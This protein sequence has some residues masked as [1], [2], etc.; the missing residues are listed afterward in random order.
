MIGKQANLPWNEKNGD[1][2]DYAM[3]A[4]SAAEAA[5]IATNK[6]RV[7]SG[8]LGYGGPVPVSHTVLLYDPNGQFEKTTNSV[9]G[10]AQFYDIHQ[11]KLTGTAHQLSQKFE[12]FEQYTAG[13]VLWAIPD[14]YIY[15]VISAGHVKLSI[16]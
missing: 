2:E 7:V 1:C 11:E 8:R 16:L 13:D 14:G 15:E 12:S 9:T 4:A 3:L 10:K 6:L 5:G